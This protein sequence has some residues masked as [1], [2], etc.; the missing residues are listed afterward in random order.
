MEPVPGCFLH[1]GDSANTRTSRRYSSTRTEIYVGR[2]FLPPGTPNTTPP[3]GQPARPQAAR[4]RAGSC[5]RGAVPA[6]PPSVLR[7]PCTWLCHRP[8]ASFFRAKN[9]APLLGPQPKAVEDLCLPA[10][11]S[12]PLPPHT[13]TLNS[14][15]GPFLDLEARASTPEAQSRH[16]ARLSPPSP[17]G[18]RGV[19]ATARPPGRL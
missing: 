7:R 11:S 12:P 17:N 9:T 2:R 13:Q 15:P 5:R 16:Q 8:R 4:S 3:L 10:C 14:D 18:G 6:A 19:K 1:Q